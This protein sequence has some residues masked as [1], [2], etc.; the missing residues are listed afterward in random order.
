MVHFIYFYLE[1][2]FSASFHFPPLPRKIGSIDDADIPD[3]LAESFALVSSQPL[4]L[5][6]AP[7]QLP[8]VVVGVPR[9]RSCCTSHPPCRC[10]E[11]KRCG[12]RDALSR[13]V[14]G[15][16]SGA[17]VSFRSYK[18]GKE[19]A[20]G[21]EAQLGGGNARAHVTAVRKLT[22]VCTDHFPPIVD[23]NEWKNGIQWNPS[24]PTSLPRPAKPG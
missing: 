16:Y 17:S 3:S 9:S 13:D 24:S 6:Q 12:E 10:R 7:F 2:P 4:I 22:Q 19:S 20:L 1:H 18:A 14:E 15:A 23:S 5:P 8:V 21:S 11:R